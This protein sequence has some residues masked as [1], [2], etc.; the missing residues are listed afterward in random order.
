[1]G[2]SRYRLR[3]PQGV[4]NEVVHLVEKHGCRF[5]TFIDDTFT[6][7]RDRTLRICDLIEESGVDVQWQCSTRVNTVTRDMLERMAHV[8]C[9]TVTY[10]IESG[11]QGILDSIQKGITLKQVRDA[12]RCALEAGIGVFCS[13]MIPHPEDTSETVLQTKRLM[14]EMARL[15]AAVTLSFTAPYPGT[16]LYENA[17]EL[18]ITILSDNWNYFSTSR[19]PVCA[20][21]HLAL[22]EI[23]SLYADIVV[24]L[25]ELRG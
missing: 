25:E 9:T 19:G 3:S 2:G 12:V 8:G 1:M 18:G 11:S 10:G 22:E 23:K 5:F 14:V 15:G 7:F 21:K 24:T 6:V 4:I 16:Y 17:K 13:F 20:T